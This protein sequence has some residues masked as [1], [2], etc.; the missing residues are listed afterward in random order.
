[1]AYTITNTLTNLTA[2]GDTTITSTATVTL[3]AAT[4][5]RVPANITVSGA[6]YTYDDY[7][8]VT[9]GV[10]TLSNPT[11]NVTITAVGLT[12]EERFNADMDG[13]V[14][15]INA[16]AGTTGDK[17]LPQVKHTA[18]TITTA[19]T[20]QTKTVALSMASGDQT[21]TPDTGKVLTQ[22][23]V[24]KPATL[25]AG[26]IKDGTTIGGVTGTFSHVASNGATAGDILSGKKA[27]VN[28][29]EV[30]GNI[31][32][33]SAQTY[34]PTTTDQTIASGQYLAGAQTIEGIVCTNLLPENIKDGVTVKIGTATDD[35][36]VTTVVGTYQGGGSDKDI[37]VKVPTV[38]GAYTYT[39]AAQSAVISGYYSGLMTKSGT[40]SATNAGTYS[41]TFT[42]NDTTT[43]A[44]DDGT[45]TAKTLT[46]S[47]AKAALP[48]PTIS[49]TS[50]NFNPNSTSGTM[51]VTRI[52]DG[53]ITATSSDTNVLTAS[54]SGTTVTLT[55]IDTSTDTNETVTVTVAEGTNYLAYTATDVVA[56]V[57]IASVAPLGY[58]ASVTGLGNEDPSTVVFT[59][60]EDFPTS[61]EEVTSNGDVFVKIP[62]MYRKVDAVTDNQITAFTMATAQI[63]GDY[64][65]YP[66][67]VDENG[68]TLDYILIGK[69]WNTSSNSMNSTTE[70]SSTSTKTIGNARTQAQARGTG[71]QQFDWMMQ[72]FW[73]DLIILLKQTVNTNAGT[74]WTYDDIG[75]YWGTAYG[76]VDG[77][78]QNSTS[79]A[80]SYAPTKFADSATSATTGYTGVSYQLPTSTGREIQ[81][82]GYDANNP[83]VN[84]PSAV[85][86]NSSYNT[87]YCDAYYYSSGNH[88]LSSYVGYASANYGA[89]Y[90]SVNVGWSDAFSVR[91]CYRPL[92]A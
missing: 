8:D 7:T 75:I 9:K 26:N 45:T 73:Q 65:P 67:F 32:S 69:Y 84:Y 44:W 39:G 25:A 63:D 29:A 36:S 35:D 89:F 54:V 53:A 48:K 15:V 19:K 59:R 21:I 52:G 34:T 41:V 86:S 90:C 38:T 88:P 81:K 3:S 46:W 18:G 5:Y 62:T 17:Y 72:R 78:A 6:D 13:I 40:E 74:A 55:A 11:G 28:G 64:K 10:I 47:I 4:G 1:M 66:C 57:A 58:T 12:E 22:V 37:T 2:S 31:A 82:L 30:T 70:T 51:T 50:F 68:S 16:K 42:L 92:S 60:D 83:F 23:T 71:Y 61:F 80:V 14:D 91:L 20:E 79:I 49:P 24:E 77:F 56:D 27:Y 43:T 33:K 87:Y 76:W 85:V